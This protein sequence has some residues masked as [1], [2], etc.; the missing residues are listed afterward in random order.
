MAET[1][2]IDV[3]KAMSVQ[4]RL[5]LIERIWET[6]DQEELP[7]T[8]WQKKLLDERL[9]EHQRNPNSGRPWDEIWDGVRA[10]RS[11]RDSK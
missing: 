9:D 1:I 7:L 3:I 4:Q 11:E 2:S 5:N 10:L 8:D 6:I